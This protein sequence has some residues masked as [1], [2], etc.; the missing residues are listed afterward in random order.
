MGDTQ[1]LASSLCPVTLVSSLVESLRMK[2]PRFTRFGAVLVLLLLAVAFWVLQHQLQALHYHDI[3]RSMAVIP[4]W[5]LC[6]AIIL[7]VLSYLLLTGYD[8]LALHYLRHRLRYGKIALASFVGYVFSY[9][10][11]L[12]IL[13]GSAIR[14]RFYSCWGLSTGEIAK[15]VAFCSLTFWLGV[16]A[17]A[18]GALI[19][20]PPRL[21]TA[22][23]LP[24][25]YARFLGIILV[26]LVVWYL[27]WGAVKKTPL[28]LLG[29]EFPL[30]STQLSLGQI[31]LST[32]DWCLAGSVSYVLLPPSSTLSY[33]AF[34]GIY[35]LAQVAGLI[36]H[37]PGGI[38]IF[39]TVI[40]LFLA[41]RI[42]ASSVLGSLVAYR[43]IYYLLPLAVASALLA[44]HEVIGK[45]PME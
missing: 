34:L 13:G 3:V 28:K 35:V 12:S 39:E 8:A 25:T 30:P 16:L 42:P 20:E 22:L 19:M 7:T 23:P 37:I 44:A 33:P 2:R 17:I 43:G 32:L 45:K 36:S 38:G 29:W 14:Y 31:G 11:G 24:F 15:V 26:G 10:V 21:L 6:L 27:A 18:G 4:R 5:R 9:N 40:L 41:P 1:I